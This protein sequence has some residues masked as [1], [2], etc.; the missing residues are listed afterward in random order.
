MRSA[1]INIRNFKYLFCRISE[2]QK[3]VVKAAETKPGLKD[4]KAGDKTFEALAKPVTKPIRVAKVDPL[5]PLPTAAKSKK[6]TKD[7][8]TAR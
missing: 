3:K 4:K 1:T 2:R 7:S 6:T 5:A 8:G